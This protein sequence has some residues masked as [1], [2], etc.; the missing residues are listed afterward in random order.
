MDKI[1]L[2]YILILTIFCSHLFSST[3]VILSGAS[4]HFTSKKQEK[5]TSSKKTIYIENG[6]QNE[7]IIYDTVI[8]KKRYNENH[9]P[10][11]IMHG[12]SNKY[13]VIAIQYKNSI[14]KTSNS[15][16]LSRNFQTNNYLSF[17]INTGIVNGYSKQNALHPVM[18]PSMTLKYKRAAIDIAGT[19]EVIFASFRFKIW[20]KP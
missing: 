12:I 20:D 17:S 15:L 13:S 14:N 2:K 5:I 11:G 10:I 7:E 8:K 6:I 9:Q 19:H 16:T 1:T 4:H 3:Y 18:F